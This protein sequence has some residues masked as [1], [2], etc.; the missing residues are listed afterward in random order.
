MKPSRVAHYG[1]PV[2]DPPAKMRE[3]ECSLRL[4]FTFLVE[5]RSRPRLMSATNGVKL[6]HR[7]PRR[8]ATYGMK[9]RGTSE[10]VPGVGRKGNSLIAKSGE[11][12]GNDTPR[13]SGGL[14]RSPAR[15]AAFDAY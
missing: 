15:S 1:S 7:G 3:S 5:M 12:F 10:W 11:P 14:A 2:F 6:W 4:G 9:G 8:D 13:P